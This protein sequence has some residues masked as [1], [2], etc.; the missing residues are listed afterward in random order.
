MADN[1]VR[2]RVRVDD[3]TSH[4]FRSAEQNAEH[5]SGG[6]RDSLGKLGAVAAG[7][8]AAIG[9]GLA[10]ATAAAGVLKKALDASIE[11]A[12]VG[13]MIGAQGGGTDPKR[14]A[15]LGQ[16]AGKV[17]ADNFGESIQEAGTA[18]RDA[19]RNHLLPEDAGD[20]AVKAIS[21][22]LLTLGQVAETDTSTIARSIKQMLRTG[23]VESADEAF[24]VLTVGFQNGADAAGDLLDTFTEYGT[25]FRKLGIDG[26]TAMGLLSQGLKGGARDADLVADAFKE[27]S[28]RAVDG[29]KT[30]AEGF[31]AL[32]LDAEKMTA[33]FA[34][35]GKG[36]ADGLQVVLERLRA[37]KDPVLQ[38]QTAVAL[39][40][41]QAEDLGKALYDLNPATA[42]KGLGDVAGAADKASAALGQGLGPTM[43]TFKRQAGQA[44]AD[45]GDKIAPKILESI[46]LLRGFASDIGHIF[47]G[48]KVP[49]EVTDALKKMAHD[50]LPALKEGLGYVTD[51][52]RENKDEF[53]KVGHVL[54]EYV[55]PAI[56]FL[57]VNGVGVAAMAIGGLIDSLAMVVNIGEEVRKAVINMV[58]SIVNN[59]DQVITAAAKAFAWV[60]G[61]GPK[62]EAAAKEVHEFVQQVNSELKNIRDEDVY[63]RTHFVGGQGQSRGGEFRTGG[64]QGAA[65][66]GVRNGLTKVGEEGIEFLRLPTGASVYP[67]ANAEQMDTMSANMGGAG[68]VVL[69]GSD[70]SRMGDLIID[71]IETAMR[72]KGGRPEL[73][74]IK[75]R[76]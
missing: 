72:A 13:A 44:F 47:D 26:Q 62:L 6:I 2:I 18:V 21:E 5:A 36:A 8:G 46:E 45:L 58:L 15:E 65:T 14:M 75:I 17:Y 27:F 32:G 64:I 7:A 28:I 70:G 33:Q 38:G 16:L 55:I 66:G 41:T 3:E 40:G 29:S 60:P 52:V 57:L 42:V 23:L 51:K 37:I 25:Q 49:T 31:K 61:L 11:R 56:G 9:A 35:G 76:K 12:N 22:K 68:G 53:E 20:D 67:R 4:G 1:D 48:S 10:V 19:I 34:K 71:I 39:F 74:G 43:E 30:S 69:L 59:F 73:L 63:V 24:D 54:A 50:Y